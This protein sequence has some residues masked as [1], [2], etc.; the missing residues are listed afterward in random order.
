VQPLRILHI[1]PK[2]TVSGAEN[3]AAYLML[4]LARSHEV[5]AINLHPPS[6]SIIEQSLRR[7]GI[8][9]WYLG[10]REGFDPRMFPAISKVVREVRPEIVHSH[11][12]VLRYMLPGMLLHRIP[13]SI[14][15]VHNTAE[16]EV[17]RVGQTIH[18]IAFRCNVFPVA[19]SQEV[20]RSVKRVY[21]LDPKAIIPNG[22]PVDNYVTCP[23]TRCLWRMKEGF[24][25][26][27]VLFTCVGRLDL[28]KNPMMLLNAFAAI[29]NPK[30]HLVLIG[31]GAL[32][33]QLR[34]EAHVFGIEERVHF[35]GERNDVTECL[36]AAD[37]FVLTSDWEGNPLSVMEAMASG[38]PVIATAVGGVPE[39]IGKDGILVDPGD[40]S[41][42]AENMKE[43]LQDPER[44][45]VL[46]NAARKRAL[47]HFRVEQM[48]QAYEL[49]YRTELAFYRKRR[50]G[51]SNEIAD[52]AGTASQ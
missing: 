11:L 50:S 49:L 30:S 6:D 32:L 52:I 46:G 34:R 16:H 4:H 29:S 20:A 38:L 28:Q 25:Q 47:D 45:L 18:K 41:R 8:P 24:E 3:M 22:I 17:D 2:L 12:S 7:V 23:N 36:A 26:D 21:G 19:I 51:A 1:L 13:V 27:W 9:V 40:C 33:P 5:S 35:L 31:D 15:T 37:V 14:H 44:R 48:V 10:K 43:L 39:L 42:F